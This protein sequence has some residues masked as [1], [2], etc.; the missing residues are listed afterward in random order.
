[1]YYCAYARQSSRKSFIREEYTS[2][3]ST[4]MHILLKI[5]TRRKM[6]ICPARVEGKDPYFLLGI[7]RRRWAEEW[8]RTVIIQTWMGG[9]VA[10]CD[11]FNPTHERKSTIP[12]PKFVIPVYAS[13]SLLNHYITYKKVKLLQLPNKRKLYSLISFNF[14]FCSQDASLP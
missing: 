6:K 7:W 5:I 1:M 9:E 11:L 8:N 2:F 13:L 3:L 14:I 4:C 12:A 10:S